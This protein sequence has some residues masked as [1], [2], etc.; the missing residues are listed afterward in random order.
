MTVVVATKNAHKVRELRALLRLPKLRLLCLAD[1]PAA[2]TVRE[3]GRTFKENAV[4]KARAVAN[5]SGYLALADDSGIEVQALGWAPGVKSARFAGRHGN[6]AANNRKLLRLLQGL[7][8]SKR[9]AR[10]RCVLALA[11]PKT[12]LAVTEGRW[13]GRIAYAPAG[14]R[15]FGYD[16]IVRLPSHRKTVAQLTAAEK[17]RLSHRARAAK[18]MRVRL[19]SLLRRAK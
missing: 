7:S 14:Q 5:A 8:M 17:N 1:L 19:V 6:D 2:P 15:G 9:Q 3:T 12:L 18:R 16:P 4:K 11:S 13:T 10:Y